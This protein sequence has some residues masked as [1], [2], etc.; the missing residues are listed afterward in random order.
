MQL[1][2]TAIS[3][4]ITLMVLALIGTPATAFTAPNA[5]DERVEFTF[6]FGTYDGLYINERTDCNEGETTLR[7]YGEES[8]DAAFP[9]TH[10]EAPFDPS[11]SE[12]PGTDFV[13]FNPAYISEY[14]Y[15]YVDA[16]RIDGVDAREKVFVKQWYVPKY[17][18][19][20]GNVW[21]SQ[22]QVESA[23]IVTEYTYML[24]D[25]SNLPAAG[26]ADSGTNFWFPI[27]SID[28][29]IGLDSF[30]ITTGDWDVDDPT[31][32]TLAEIDD[33]DL[34]E[35]KDI[36][37][38]TKDPVCLYDADFNDPQW[39]S[40]L[41][42]MIVVKNIVSN[43]NDVGVLIDVY[44]IG[45]DEPE[46][47]YTNSF[48]K[49]GDEPM[50]FGRSDQGSDHSPDFKRP[51]YIKAEYYATKTVEGTE[52]DSV[53]VTIG[54]RLHTEETFFVDGA[55]YDIA[56]IYGPTDDTFKYITI[57]NP[58]PKLEDVEL[59]TLTITKLHVPACRPLPM[60]PPFNMAHTM[61]D[62]INIP[63]NCPECGDCDKMNPVNC[64]IYPAYVSIGD[65][66]C[67]SDP[68]SIHW[69]RELE[70]DRFLTSLGEIYDEDADT[71]CSV[72]N[73]WQWIRTQTIP[74]LYT[75]MSYPMLP[76]AT[77]ETPEASWIGD[78]LLVSSWEA[79][80]SCENRV[81]FVFDAEDSTDIYL[82]DDNVDS[83]RIY[84]EDRIDGAFPYTDAEGPFN[85]MSTN[86]HGKDF[87]T[88][89]PAYYGDNG[90]GEEKVFVRQWYVPEY[91]MPKGRVWETQPYEY[92]ACIVTEYSYM[93]LDA[94]N[95]PDAATLGK[96]FWLPTGYGDNQIGLEDNTVKTNDEKVILKAVGD[97]NDPVDGKKDISVSSQKFS[98]FGPNGL[99]A[100]ERLEFIDHEIVIRTIESDMITVDVY[101]SGKGFKEI[102]RVIE[103]ITLD[104]CNDQITSGGMVEQV[105][106]VEARNAPDFEHPWYA[107]TY[108]EGSTSYLVVGRHLHMGETFFVNG[109]EYD[110]SM[111]YGP[112]TN[113]F[114]YITLRNPIPKVEYS[115]QSGIDLHN[116][117]VGMDRIDKNYNLPMLPP[118]NQPHDI[119]DDIG[120]L[121]D[122]PDFIGV[123]LQE[124]QDSCISIHYDMIE[125]RIVTG[126]PEFVCSY[127]EEDKE[128]RFTTNL[129]EILDEGQIEDWQWMHI[130]TRP[131]HYTAMVYPDVGDKDDQE[132]DFILTTSGP[133]Q[134]VSDWNAWDDDCQITNT[135]IS[136]AEYYWATNT[137]VNGHTITNAEIS[138]LEGQWATGIVC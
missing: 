88:F 65:R 12:A 22:E 75:E 68:L 80:N 94:Y 103:G 10:A 91:R 29:Q 133:K 73:L 67:D 38:E 98:I 19:P 54:R 78:F 104:I 110:I 136:N 79:P 111:I 62:D 60:L 120:I 114:L 27:G 45:N 66:M 32:V 96:E 72:C 83:V 113:D 6:G 138:L 42:H 132:A 4:L 81:K 86:A 115:S 134:G 92:E 49:I 44:Y 20:L 48:V 14:E 76:E 56:A 55:G 123:V 40:F 63:F 7:I 90:V 9:Y 39:V 122:C 30:N 130:I 25:D 57:R 1:N 129:L 34:D 24:L 26:E 58:T 5:S 102:E 28:D 36:A 46:E 131:D 11:N 2:N 118:F 106:E 69:V 33:Y 82:N 100:G 35:Q 107:E 97:F 121:N 37:I 59:S 21:A 126:Q 125:E 51:W 85:K 101:Y 71:S 23:D 64:E 43:G 18:E 99:K 74:D 112:N 108:C 3:I 47:I 17:P 31:I 70:E 87:V 119:V 8:V 50:F 61:I 89:N 95:N 15:G 105:S 77:D 137:P 16:I 53:Y 84:G 116:L 124:E 117:D 13:V 109:M 93:L 135:E 128:G 52:Y 41:D 127:S